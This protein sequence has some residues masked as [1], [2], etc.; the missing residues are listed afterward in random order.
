MLK[1]TFYGGRGRGS[2]EISE[3]LEPAIASGSDHQVLFRGRKAHV[4]LC[5]RRGERSPAKVNHRRYGP[6]KH[7]FRR[8]EALFPRLPLCKGRRKFDGAADKSG[9]FT[10]VDGYATKLRL[11]DI[12][13][14]RSNGGRRF[15]IAGSFLCHR[16]ANGCRPR[17]RKLYVVRRHP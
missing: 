16:L 2:Q 15:Q 3:P 6:S 7:L 9:K 11:S 1:C 12:S 8:F 5:C 14:P 10:M 13:K 4:S 17:H